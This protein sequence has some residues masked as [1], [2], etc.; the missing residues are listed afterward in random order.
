M[1]WQH[2]RRLASGETNEPRFNA[3]VRLIDLAFDLLPIQ[4]AKTMKWLDSVM[5]ALGVLLI[6]SSVVVLIHT[7]ILISLYWG[8]GL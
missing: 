8:I 5:T 6:L 3:G 4:E 2:V 1:N 7:T